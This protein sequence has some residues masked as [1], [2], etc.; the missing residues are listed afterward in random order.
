VT[1][2]FRP[3]PA[4]GRPTAAPALMMAARINCADGVAS[5]AGDGEPSGRAS[6]ILI[7]TAT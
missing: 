2:I 5:A 7:S 3:S 6:G 4:A 1:P